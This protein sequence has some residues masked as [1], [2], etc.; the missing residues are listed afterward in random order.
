MTKVDRVEIS[1][2][3]GGGG[4][5]IYPTVWV[6]RGKTVN[7]YCNISRDSISRVLVMQ[8][9]ILDKAMP[10]KAKNADVSAIDKEDMRSWARW[11][12]MLE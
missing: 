12:N 8:A 5:G 3:N 11:E 7:Y 9:R 4:L 2:T 6:H 10:R 1:S